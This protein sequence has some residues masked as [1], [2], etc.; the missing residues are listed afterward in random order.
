MTTSSD[1]INRFSLQRYDAND[2]VVECVACNGMG[3]SFK[4]EC[5]RAHV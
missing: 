1:H 3:Q 4:L 5:L 2:Q